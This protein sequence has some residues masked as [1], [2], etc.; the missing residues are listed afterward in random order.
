MTSLLG[1]VRCLLRYW[2]TN[3]LL[4][5]P[6][7][8]TMTSAPPALLSMADALLMMASRL[9]VKK[10]AMVSADNTSLGVWEVG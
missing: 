9:G 2:A 3:L 7:T 6:P 8:S 1:D 4:L 5:N 10:E